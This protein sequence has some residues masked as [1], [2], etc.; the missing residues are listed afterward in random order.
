M[1]AAKSSG[2]G[3]RVTVRP[4]FLLYFFCSAHDVAGQGKSMELAAE[5]GRS[6]R[7]QRPLTAGLLLFFFV[8]AVERKRKRA[9]H[10]VED[11]LAGTWQLDRL[12]E[13]AIGA[14]VELDRLRPIVKGAGDEDLGSG[15]FPMEDRRVSEK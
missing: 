4:G 10:L 11:L 2:D 14:L 9:A 1:G 7:M 3:R 6:K 8:R 15:M 13:D 5:T 12:G